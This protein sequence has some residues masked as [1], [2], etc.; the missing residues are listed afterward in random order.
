M[1]VATQFKV[2]AFLFILALASACDDDRN[3][4]FPAADG[5][6]RSCVWLKARPSEMATLCLPSDPSGAYDICEETCGKCVDNCTQSQTQPIEPAP[7]PMSVIQNIFSY[8][9]ITSP[10]TAPVTPTNTES[11][12]TFADIRSPPKLSRSAHSDVAAVTATPRSFPETPPPVDPGMFCDDERYTQFYVADIGQWQRCGWLTFRFDYIDV[13]CSRNDP[14]RAYHICAE[15]C[16]KCTDSCAEYLDTKFDVNG[17]L[18]DCKWLRFRLDMHDMLCFPGSAAFSLCPETCNACDGKTAAQNPNIV[19]VGAY[20]YPWHSDDFH[21]GSPYLR[22]NLSPKQRPVL[23]EYDDRDPAVIAQHLRWSRQANIQLWVTSWWGPGSRED[24]ATLTSILPHTD[25]G[26]HKIALFYETNGIISTKKNY[27]TVAVAPDMVHMSKNYFSHPNYFKI[28]GRPVI[29]MYV[30]RKYSQ[31]GL[32]EG[33]LLLMRQTAADYGFNPYIIGDQVFRTAPTGVYPPFKQLDAV[34]N[35]DVRGGMIVPVGTNYITQFQVDNFYIEQGKWKA[36]ASKEGCAFV[37][38]VS[39]GYND[40][41]VRLSAG[42][43]AVSRRLN[44]QDVEGSLFRAALKGARKVADATIN[45]LV[46]INSFNEWHEDSQIEPTDGGEK[47]VEPFNLTQG[48]EYE[49][50][51]EL[52]LNILREETV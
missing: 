7:T 9:Q 30:S 1:N 45:N 5:V 17:I 13:L 52:Y 33:I 28:N 14:S 2:F 21:R 38:P 24:T 46:M 6:L 44:A 18:R 20:Y 3:G 32:L 29:F 27:T 40:R 48:V 16:G 39:P 37:P 36:A 26:T 47:T 15:T 25:L 42:N 12:T 49:A 19:T 41:A 4:L 50:Y 43:A 23:G 22:D 31:L 11:Q 35:Y 10:P 34:T 51:G 8:L